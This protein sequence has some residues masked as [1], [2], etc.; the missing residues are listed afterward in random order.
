M[1]LANSRV[2]DMVA[3]DVNAEV[4]ALRTGERALGAL[5]DR[6]G[7]PTFRASVERMLDHGEALVRAYFDRLPDGGYRAE[8]CSTMT[9]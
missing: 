8:G 9:A 3:G 7:L 4:V 2:P 5:V 6:H 1:A